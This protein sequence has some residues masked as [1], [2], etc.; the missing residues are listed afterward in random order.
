MTAIQL[1]AGL[2]NPGE[3]YRDTRHNA[4]F[5]FVNR[6]AREGGGRFSREPRFHGEVAR[7]RIPGRDDLWLLKP[8]TYM[9]DSG[10]AVGA[11]ARFYRIA[12]EQIL[13]V[14]DELDLA[15]GAVRLKRGGG[16][17]GHRGTR[18]VAAV[19]GTHDFWRLRL[20]IGHP[21]DRNQ[22]VDHVL[23]RPGKDEQSL[24]DEAIERAMAVLPRLLKGEMEAGIMSL[25]APR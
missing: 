5:W 22:V 24:I 3:E 7:L 1:I 18:D 4:G 12:A 9:N 20:G 6:V 23:H 2:G 25:H 16:H 11:L 13:V 19:L 10:R 15:P 17:A 14:H 8:L 21:G